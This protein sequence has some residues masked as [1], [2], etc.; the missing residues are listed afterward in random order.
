MKNALLGR[1]FIQLLLAFGFGA[2]AHLSFAPYSIEWLAPLSLSFLYLQ[3]VAQTFNPKQHGWLGLSFGVGLFSF[4][5]RWVHVSIDNFGGLPLAVSLGLML[6]LSLYLA[7]FSA[8]VCYLFSKI[9]TSSPLNNALLFSSLWVAFE[10]IRGKALTGFPWLWLGYSQT[11]GIF[12]QSAATI[13]AIGLSLLICLIASLSVASIVD[14]SKSCAAVLTLTLLGAFSLNSLQQITQRDQSVDVAL[15]QGNIEQSAKWQSDSMWPTIST[16]MDLTRDNLDAELIF[17][18]EAA[19]PAVETWVIDYLKLM[20]KTAN[21]RDSAIITG[22]IAR[23]ES[24]S[25]NSPKTADYYNALVT[26]GNFEQ[27]TQKSGG[28]QLNHSNRYYKHQLLPIG[29]FVPF[30]DFLRPLAPL[31]NLPMSSFARGQWQQP[32]LT[33]LGYQIAPAICYE[34][35][36]PHLVRA[37]MTPQTDL[38][39]TVSNDAW[40]GRSIGPHQHMEI[41]QMRAIELGRPLLRV[42]NNGVTAIVDTTGVITAQLPQFEPGVLRA[43]VNLVSGLTYFYRWGQWPIIALIILLIWLSIVRKIN[44]PYKA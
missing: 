9:R 7:L 42:T 34:I 4:G 21:F 38:L 2:L 25:A 15:V 14:R 28:Y 19:M 6:L 41:A 40:F 43:N 27:K 29:E 18:P 36:F 31:F 12:S 5:L 13:G 3:I 30:E 16:Y 20:D 11:S 10:L 35:A 17:W 26:L 8:M 24:T 37:N 23:H 44:R 33:A 32:N 39:L 22:I 1:F